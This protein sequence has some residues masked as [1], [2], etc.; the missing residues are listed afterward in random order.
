MARK[1][2]LLISL[3]SGLS[4]MGITSWCLAVHPD[5][6]YYGESFILDEW[7]LIPFLQFKPITLMVYLG[8]I[9]WAFFLEGMEG[10][11]RSSAEGWLRFSMVAAALVSFGSLYEM[12]FNF[13]LWGALMVVTDVVNPDILVNRFPMTETAV[14]LVYASKLVLLAF[15]TST[16][17][18]LFLLRTFLRRASQ[19]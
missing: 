9:S 1:V 8:F 5:F 12:F 14:S 13:S 16:Y 11:F 2:W 15:A 3:I 4:A 18:L 17:T 6:S 19:T 7:H 10:W